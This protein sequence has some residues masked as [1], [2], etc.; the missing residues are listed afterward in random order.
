MVTTA[1]AVRLISGA[2]EISF[3]AAIRAGAL[4]AGPNRKQ[5][6]D[7]FTDNR[8]D[9]QSDDK[10]KERECGRAAAWLGHAHEIAGPAAVFPKPALTRRRTLRTGSP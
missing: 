1:G 10:R 6:G 3:G 5:P 9:Q 7:D 4:S 2:S 8:G